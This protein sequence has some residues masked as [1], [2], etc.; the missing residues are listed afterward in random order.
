MNKVLNEVI[1]SHGMLEVVM[2]LQEPDRI[3]VMNTGETKVEIFWG[4]T[5][6]GYGVTL[7]EAI[8]FS[9]KGVKCGRVSLTDMFNNKV[10]GIKEMYDSL[11]L[12]CK[13]MGIDYKYIDNSPINNRILLPAVVA[14]QLIDYRDIKVNVKTSPIH[15]IGKDDYYVDGDWNGF[16]YIV[17][18]TLNNT[19]ISE[20]I[21]GFFGRLPDI[22]HIVCEL[23]L[24]HFGIKK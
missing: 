3:T 22:Q 5:L 20:Q 8:N 21:L 15:G 24:K 1:F 12:L 10:N 9:L 17:E 18:I 23:A 7:P 11:V 4:N 19:T 6:M 16:R 2:K 14:T 13:L